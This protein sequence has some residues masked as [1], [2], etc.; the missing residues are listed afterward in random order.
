VLWAGKYRKVIS[1]LSAGHRFG[2]GEQC[3]ESVRTTAAAFA[4]VSPRFCPSERIQFASTQTPSCEGIVTRVVRVGGREIALLETFSGKAYAVPIPPS[5]SVRADLYQAMAVAQLVHLTGTKLSPRQ[6]R[7]LS[8]ATA[9]DPNSELTRYLAYRDQE[10]P[11]QQL[12]GP[13]PLD[14]P[15][16]VRPTRDEM[17][18]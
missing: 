4:S 10:V 7:A 2:S 17:S 12:A 5:P 8:R 6:G 9:I 18:F 3:E 1:P 14:G 13:H 16:Q 15:V 11:R